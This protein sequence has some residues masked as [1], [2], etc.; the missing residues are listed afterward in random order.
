M[1]WMGKVS[2]L[3]SKTGKSNDHQ[4]FSFSEYQAHGIPTGM[5]ADPLEANTN[6]SITVIRNR[7][8]SIYSKDP[9]ENHSLLDT[10]PTNPY[11]QIAAEDTAQNIP[12]SVCNPYDEVDLRARQFQKRTKEAL[13]ITEYNTD[14]GSC[15][16]P[17]PEAVI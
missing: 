7:S 8:F 11:V 3:T 13:G 4:D 5:S 2:V 10:A 1:V 16:V 6:T 12:S 14:M 17:H 15:P 9:G